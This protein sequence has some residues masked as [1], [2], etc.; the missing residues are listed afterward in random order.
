MPRLFL[1]LILGLMPYV[2]FAQHNIACINDPDGFTNV[3][4]TPGLQSEITGKI[5]NEEFFYCEPNANEWWK[6]T[7]NGMEG[8]IHRSRVRMLNDLPDS[9]NADIFQRNFS[10]Y[11]QQVKKKHDIW[12]KYNEKEKRWR[13]PKDSLAYKKAR[14]EHGRQFETKLDP[15]ML[16]FSPYF[17]RT[18]D[19]ATLILVFRYMLTDTGSASETPDDTVGEC[20]ICQPETVLQVIAG[21]PRKERGGLYAAVELGLVNH[22]FGK[23]KETVYQRLSKQLKDAEKAP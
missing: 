15:L 12:L 5:I 16:A 21:F 9:V 6:I 14:K 19:T 1:S 13:D 20:Y 8:Y 17:C 22:S 4:K 11:T 7:M 2:S 3:R 10:Q 18:R 23:E